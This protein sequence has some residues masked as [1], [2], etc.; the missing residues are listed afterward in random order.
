MVLKKTHISQLGCHSLADADVCDLCL[1]IKLGVVHGEIDRLFVIQNSHQL[2]SCEVRLVVLDDQLVPLPSLHIC[3]LDTVATDRRRT[4]AS[5][6]DS[7]D[8]L[9][10]WIQIALEAPVAFSKAIKKDREVLWI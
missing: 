7:I 8:H 2:S 3:H 4:V 1:V 5:G 10:I 9:K 6:Q